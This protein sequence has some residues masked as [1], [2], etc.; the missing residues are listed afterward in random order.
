MVPYLLSV[1]AGALL[2]L[3]FAPFQQFWLA[4][5]SYAALF[6]V[7]RDAAPRRALGLGFAYGC[8]SFG[9]GTYWTYIAVAEFGEAPIALAGLL[10]VG[11]TVVLAAFVALAGWTAARW[12]PTRGAVACL[13]TFPASFVLAEWLRSFAFSGFGWLA[14]GYSQTDSWLMGYAPVAGIHAMSLAVLVTAGALLT[15]WRGTARERALAAIVLA[16]VW[17]GG[18]A[19]RAQTFTTAQERSLAVALVQG[20]VTQDLK[21]RPEQLPGTLMLYDQLTRQSAG[22]DLIIWPEAAIPTLYEYVGEYL[23]GVPGAVAAAQDHDLVPHDHSVVAHA[24]ARHLADDCARSVGVHLL[25]STTTYA[26]ID[27]VVP[28]EE[29]GGVV[30]CRLGKVRRLDLRGRSDGGVDAHHPVGWGPLP[31]EPAQQVE[32]ATPVGQ[33]H[34]TGHPDV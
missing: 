15:L 16:G 21:W 14:A 34:G 8:A 26:A 33:R 12:F 9:F 10:T 1:L 27:H 20:A 6:Y 22:A 30:C 24:P 2:P 11:L 19:F 18:F 4:P 32:A 3:A 31:V 7:W 28:V 25:D 5:L 29:N 17:A 13:A 23:E